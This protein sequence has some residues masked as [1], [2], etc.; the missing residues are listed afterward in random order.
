MKWCGIISI[1]PEFVQAFSEVGMVRK[2]IE[3]QQ[4][5]V[6]AIN[7]R[8]F[9]DHPAGYVDDRP[10]GGGAGML[11]KPEPLF[12]AIQYAKQSAPG[13][14]KVI[15]VS[16]AGERLSQSKVL[17]VAQWPENLIIIAGRYE[18]IDQRIIDSE[19]DVLLSI[20]DYVI[21]GG[22]LAAMV[23][24]D[25]MCRWLP[26][27]LGHKDSAA[28]DAFS[29]ANNGLLDCPHYTRPAVFNGQAVPGVLLSGDHA[30]ID[31]WRQ[32]KILQQT[33][34]YRPDLLEE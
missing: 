11:F 7:L 1:F 14:C 26:G 3:Q 23:I 30:A 33:S 4:L 20:G 32:E 28:N 27:V 19:V 13:P 16:P 25:A 34:Q 5:V 2:A 12:K 29:E 21:S 31:A 17:E 22:E 8:D 9:S 24:V 6:E 10:F 15:Y 18:G